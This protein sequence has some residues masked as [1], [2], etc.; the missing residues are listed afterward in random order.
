M[1][2]DARVLIFYVF[3]ND[4]KQVFVRKLFRFLLQLILLRQR[5][6]Q[7]KPGISFLGMFTISESSV[8]T[9]SN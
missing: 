8:L 4:V 6:L 3:S 9:V 7:D 1:T 5:A 2:R